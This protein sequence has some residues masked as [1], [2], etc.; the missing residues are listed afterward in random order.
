MPTAYCTD[1]VAE[2][3]HDLS[4]AGLAHSMPFIMIWPIEA[5]SRCPL[6]GVFRMT[7]GQ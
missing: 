4:V 6:F 5:R 1:S 2:I 3:M 7:F